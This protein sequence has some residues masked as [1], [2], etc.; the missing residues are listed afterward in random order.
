MTFAKVRSWRKGLRNNLV[1]TRVAALWTALGWPIASHAGWPDIPA[2]ADGYWVSLESGSFYYSDLDEAAKAAVEYRCRHPQGYLSGSNQRN[3]TAASIT[4]EPHSFTGDG[5]GLDEYDRIVISMRYE[6][7]QYP[8]G[9]FASNY[10][11]MPVRSCPPGYGLLSK[12]SGLNPNRS[13]STSREFVRCTPAVNLPSERLL[14]G[15]TGQSKLSCMLDASQ[16]VG[17]PINAGTLSKVQREVDILSASSL[18]K[19]ERIYNSG[20]VTPTNRNFDKWKVLPKPERIGARWR[21]NFDRSLEATRYYDAESGSYEKAAQVRHADGSVSFFELRGDRYVAATG[22]AGRL[23]GSGSGWEYVDDDGVRESFDSMGRLVAIF[24]R[25]SESIFLT[26][27]NTADGQSRLALATD[28]SGRSIGFVYDSSG[29]VGEV[30]GPDGRVTKYEYSDDGLGA[31]LVGITRA[32]QSHI[33]YLYDEP[34]HVVYG[35]RFL[36]GIVGPDGVRFATYSYDFK[37]NAK[38]TSHAGGAGTASVQAGLSGKSSSTISGGGTTSY[39]YIDAGGYPRLSQLLSPA[40]G[41]SARSSLEVKYNDDGTPSSLKSLDGTVTTYTYDAELR[42]ETS[43]TEAVGTSEERVIRTTWDPDLRLPIRIDR[44]GQ[45]EIMK[46]DH[47]GKIIE[48]RVGGKVDAS[49]A[50][51]AVWPD[52]R[53]TTYAYHANGSILTVDGPLDGPADTHRF[54]YFDADAPDCQVSL[55]ECRWRAGDLKSVTSPLGRIYEIIRYDGAGRAVAMRDE[56]G[57]RTDLGFDTLGRLT[58]EIKRGSDG[59]QPVAKNLYSYDLVGNL[60]AV[61]DADEVTTRFR[62]DEARR[63]I[64]VD[65]PSRDRVEF[66]LDARGLRTKQTVYDLEGEV[67]YLKSTAYDALGRVSAELDSIGRRTEFTYDPVGR[68]TRIK[69]PLGRLVSRSYD[70]LGR[71]SEEAAGPAGS[72]VAASFSYD[73]LDQLR[74]VTDPNGLDTSYLR[75]GLGDLLWQSS[76]DTGESEFERDIAGAVLRSSPADGRALDYRYDAEGRVV[77]TSFSDGSSVRFVYDVASS[78]C[79][80]GERHPAGRLGQMIDKSGPTRY[81]FNA[82]GQ[83]TRKVQTTNGRDYQLRYVYSAAGRLL[84]MAYPDGTTVTYSRDGTGRV[85][86]VAVTRD[87]LGE[88]A[89]LSHILWT[90]LGQPL[91]WD[92]GSGARLARE[93]DR[94]GRTEVVRST[95]AAGL[96]VRYAYDAGGQVTATDD[97]SLRVEWSYD[98]QGRL[99]EAKDKDGSRFR[100]T[101]DSTGN[102]LSYSDIAGTLTYE[103]STGSH[104]LARAGSS[105][106]QYDA[107]GRTTLAGNVGLMYD[108][109]GRL[110]SATTGGRPSVSYA[111]NGWGERVSRSNSIAPTVT[112][113]DESGHWIGDYDEAGRPLQQ[114]IWLGDQPVAILDSGKLYDIEAD[115]LGTPRV[116]RDRSTGKR[117]WTWAIGG[118]PFGLEP[119]NED[120]D[121]DGVKFMLDLRFPGQRFD[122]YTGLVY[123][124]NRDYDASTGRYLQSDLLG[125]AGGIS[126]YSYA[127]ADPIAV[128]DPEGLSPPGKVPS[129]HSWRQ[130]AGRGGQYG[131]GIKV[132]PAKPSMEVSQTPGAWPSAMELKYKLVCIEAICSREDCSAYERTWSYRNYTQYER[133]TFPSPDALGEKDGNCRCTAVRFLDDAIRLKAGMREAAP[134]ASP[135][136]YFEVMTRVIEGMQSRRAVR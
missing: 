133:K 91:A 60:V 93:Y 84:S 26:Y 21:H 97:G 45:W 13:F 8:D 123:N 6:A 11:V 64:G 77:Q 12:S 69:D 120:V 90:P 111:Y 62:Y 35:N 113:Y 18:L 3:C 81:C 23:V 114:A 16:W 15:R 57:T 132:L 28:R 22:D 103:Y 7:D 43:R 107:V 17:N 131:Q 105:A 74:K 61:T 117:V 19:F 39:S 134:S 48:Y 52:D 79:G 25:A 92:Y 118:E 101:Y 122:G 49:Q 47:Q 80:E 14:S 34:A 104:R 135:W 106:R 5:S 86:D 59:T 136:D 73:A 98:R 36:T 58:E 27:E 66:E 71:L 44:P 40:A 46:Y 126:T 51:S 70:A 99:I 110:A 1:T 130:P 76:P 2:Y 89:V 121:A 96:N 100:Y 68:L 33:T 4:V 54:V 109:D 50:Q 116:A 37:G 95:G 125:L 55:H 108:V 42:L 29:R 32:D 53:V 112:M 63:L 119:P 75:N 78:S 10:G 85:T 31:N 102:R 94:D 127:F 124:Y 128:T 83:V 56:N 20:A 87:R 30:H 67:R 38:S 41:G 65:F 88:T 82:A 129:A 72:S 115:H 9:I 24:N